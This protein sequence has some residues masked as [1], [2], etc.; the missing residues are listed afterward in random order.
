MILKLRWSSKNTKIEIQ[1]L[2]ISERGRAMRRYR[3]IVAAWA[4]MSI[5]AGFHL[6]NAFPELI[7]MLFLMILIPQLVLMVIRLCDVAD[8]WKEFEGAVTEGVCKG[9]SYIEWNNE[10]IPQIPFVRTLRVMSVMYGINSDRAGPA[11]SLY[12]S[13]YRITKG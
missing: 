12:Q 10:K 8:R 6:R 4:I 1:F 5:M 9:V 13:G 11:I 7:P 2:R 3:V